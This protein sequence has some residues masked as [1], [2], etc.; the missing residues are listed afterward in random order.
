M[1]LVSDKYSGKGR[2]IYS[3]ALPILYGHNSFAFASANAIRAFQSKSLIGYPLGMPATFGDL[4][5]QI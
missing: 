3:E 5:E 2:M 4:L 1:A